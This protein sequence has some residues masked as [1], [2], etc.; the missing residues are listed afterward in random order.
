MAVPGGRS[1]RLDDIADVRDS[2]AEIRSKAFLD[3]KTVV[4]F[5]ITRS[6]GASEVEVGTGVQHVLQDIRRQYPGM[7]IEQAFDFVKPV[8]EEFD[9]SM[10]MLYEGALLAVWVVWLFLRD[11]RATLI[12]SLALPLSVIPAFIGM[13]YLSFIVTGKQIGR[14]HV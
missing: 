4:G 5:E 14:A 12:S 13:E 9:G 11:W 7:R 3:G 10:A 8:Q 6:R 1:I 2:V